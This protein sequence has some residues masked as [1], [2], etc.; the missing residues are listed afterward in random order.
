MTEDGKLPRKGDTKSCIGGAQAWAHN[1]Y[2]D[3]LR[4]KN[5]AGCAPAVQRLVNQAKLPRSAMRN[6]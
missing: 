2:E 4:F 5:S 1:I 3:N 6:A